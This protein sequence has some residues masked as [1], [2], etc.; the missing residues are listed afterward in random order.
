M[1]LRYF[2]GTGGALHCD[3]A[4]WNHHCYNR[5]DDPE[6]KSVVLAAVT[7]EPELFL[8]EISVA[9][10]HVAGLVQGVT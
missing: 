8:D 5:T 1:F 4:I 7:A 6:L 3:P 9:V 10:S 2:N